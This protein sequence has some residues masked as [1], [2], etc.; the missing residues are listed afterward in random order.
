MQ[1]ALYIALASLFAL[2]S[3]TTA[4]AQ[5]DKTTVS[6]IGKQQAPSFTLQTVSVR[7]SCFP[8]K[9]RII[10]AHIAAKTRRHPLITSGYRHAHRRG[11]MHNR[12][13]AADFRMPG[14]SERTVV[15]AA[16]TAPG[17]GG[18]GRYCNG[19]IHVDIGPR[20]TWVDC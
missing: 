16:R 20:R 11:S 7:A 15:E 8:E 9:L 2:S 13:M 14:V 17:I 19:I 18:I 4:D 12:C 5:T 3:C 10:L 6:S 1:N